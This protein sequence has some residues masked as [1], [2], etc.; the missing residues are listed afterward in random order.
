MR[1]LFL[2][3]YFPPEVNAPANRTFEHCRE[4]VR[5][6]HEVHVITCVPSHPKGVPFS[7]YECAWYQQEEMDGIRVHRVW[8]LL[9]PNRGVVR[10]TLNYLSF[11]PTALWRAIRVGEADILVATSPQFFCAVAGW[12][13]GTFT[14][15]PWVFELRDLWPESIHAVGALRASWPLRFLE[16]LEL[17]LY[18]SA[19]G[20]VCV[21]RSFIENLT[22]RGIDPSKLMFIPNG[23]VRQPSHVVDRRKTFEGLSIPAD[24]I[25][26][27]YVGTVGM[28]HGLGALLQTARLLKETVPEAR[29]LIVGDGAEL[30]ELL[31]RARDEGLSNLTFTGLVNHQLASD[32]LA[33]SDIALVVLKKSPLFLTVLPSKMFEAMGAGKPVVL[34]VEGEAKAVLE[35]SGG[36][37]A[38]EPENAAELAEAIGSLARDADRRLSLGA[39]GRDFVEREFDRTVWAGRYI[40]QLEQWRLHPGLVSEAL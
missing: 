16:R 37:L 7:G 18:R 5:M 36:G 33:A 26:A 10:R 25:V 17:H 35:Q 40:A 14:G 21:T 8:T 38:V 4:W 3:H 31:A 24:S 29:L 1:I 20:V 13:A 12:L 27:C 11:V 34:G 15:T 23:V 6:G 32:Y 30:P 22:K 28:A 39:L 19:R 9:S 2:T